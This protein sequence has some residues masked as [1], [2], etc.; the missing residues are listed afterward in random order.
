MQREVTAGQQ[1]DAQGG[2]VAG[3]H[4]VI[5]KDPRL[6][7]GGVVSLQEEIGAEPVVRRDPGPL[8]RQAGHPRQRRH[9]G[10]ESACQLP[11]GFETGVALALEVDPQGE[12]ALG[13]EPE[14]GS[15]EAL[16]APRVRTS[17]KAT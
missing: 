7:S 1:W 5:E 8:E 9:R 10:E 2:E 13:L 16:K 17:A 14:V 6:V 3:A 4:V 11:L 12:E 15:E